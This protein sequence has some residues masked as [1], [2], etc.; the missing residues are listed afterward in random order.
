MG[1]ISSGIDSVMVFGL[2]SGVDSDGG[3]VEEPSSLLVKWRSGHDDKLHQVYVNG[4]LA[5]MGCDFAQR[6][7]VVGVPSLFSSAL[8]V[9]VFAVL[10]GE[11]HVD[12]SDE[13]EASGQA[14]RVEV[15]WLRRMGLPREGVVDV[16]SDG[17]K[18]SREEVAIWSAWQDKSGFGLCGFGIS[19]FGFEGSAAVGFGR[20]LFG[21]GEFGFD[22]DEVVWV[23]GVLDTGEYR[24]AVKVRD[25]AG[26]EADDFESDNVVLI[27]QAL[28]V[29]A[30]EV[31]SY[32]KSEDE[33]VM[34]VAVG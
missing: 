3:S 22:C 26:N 9:E 4:E 11:G 32:D 14:G 6:M 23:S 7:L 30:I 29:E 15:G 5:G 24:F 34:R 19:D 2:S 27:R 1:L 21:G 13:L 20:G 17:V 16:Y 18:V 31:D 10:A 8:R 25:A 28:G 33:L 12:F